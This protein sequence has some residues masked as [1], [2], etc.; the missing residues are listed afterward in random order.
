MEDKSERIKAA[1]SILASEVQRKKLSGI[2]LRIVDREWLKIQLLKE[3][4]TLWLGYKIGLGYF[5]SWN[6]DEAPNSYFDLNNNPIS[7]I[8]DSLPRPAIDQRI[9]QDRVDLASELL[10]SINE[11]EPDPERIKRIIDEVPSTEE[12]IDVLA[13]VASIKSYRRAIE[14]LRDLIESQDELKHLEKEYQNILASNPWMLGSQ[15]TE[16]L[17]KEFLIDTTD[18]VDLMLASAVGHVD[19]VELKRPDTKIL[20]PGSKSNTWRAD[21]KLS[22]AQAQARKYLQILDENRLQIENKHPFA[23]Q[24][25]PRLY[26]SGAIIVAGRTPKE[27]EALS[28][29]RDINVSERRILILTYDDV[30][31]IAEATIK[32]FERKLQR[33][34]N[35]LG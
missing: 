2:K 9:S 15:Y 4:R 19:I 5:V 30:L 23:K 11:H 6:K 8:L 20:S 1:R 22:D 24:S 18:R 34:S 17:V 25:V 16:L 3:G 35:L 29:L 7:N 13:T 32:I 10:D 26:R 31:A 33:S 28:A 21:N 27:S 12:G 14:R